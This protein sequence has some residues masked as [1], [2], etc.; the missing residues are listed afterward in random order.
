V[1]PGEPT[2]ELVQQG[3]ACAH[4][5]S[6]DQVIA[7]GGGSVVDAGKAIASLMTN[8]GDIFDYIEVVGKGQQITMPP[9]PFIAIPTT[10]GTGAEVTRNAVVGSRVHG[11]KASMRSPMMLPRV[12][13]VDPELTY[14]MP[15]SVT[16]ST[17]MDALTQLL[18]SYVGIGANPMTDLLCRDG[19]MRAARSLRIAYSASEKSTFAP[20]D[21]AAREDMMYA[22]LYSGLAL[23]N[24]RLGAVHG[25]AAPIGGASDAPHG[26]ICARLLPFVMETNVRALHAPAPESTFLARY[27]DVAQILTGNTEAVAQDGVQWAHALCRD[28]RIPALNTF[29]ITQKDLRPIAEQAVPS[30]S[31]KGNPIELNMEDLEHVLHAAWQEE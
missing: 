21:T 4:E 18:E 15:P 27:D 8:P 3:V 19:M 12:A 25:L 5:H 11:V 31:M 17:G 16:A 30:R 1:V 2:I 9:A 10:A 14:S 20:E 13:L 22:G 26:A 29:G 6:C 24:S 28:L 7:C 23:A